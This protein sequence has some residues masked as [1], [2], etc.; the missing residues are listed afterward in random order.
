MT[1]NSLVASQGSPIVLNSE[2][3]AISS[4]PTN[5]G[6][7]EIT[8]R[9]QNVTNLESGESF[10]FYY[11]IAPINALGGIVGEL[12]GEAQ[13]IAPGKDVKVTV[14]GDGAVYYYLVK[15]RLSAMPVD[16]TLKADL[17][18]AES[19]LKQAQ[20]T[21]DT[22]SLKIQQLS[23]EIKSYAGMSTALAAERV[24]DTLV[25]LKMAQDKLARDNDEIEPRTTARDI[26]K[27]A[28]EKATKAAA[29]QVVL[30][31]GILPI[32]K[33]PTLKDYHRKPVYYRF[34]QSDNLETPFRLERMG[35]FPVFTVQDDL[36]LIIVNH[37]QDQK[38]SDF[39]LSYGTTKGSVIDV[40]PVRPTFEPQSISKSLLESDKPDFSHA[41]TDHLLTFA[42]KLPGETVLTVSVSSYA[43]VV[44]TNKDDGKTTTLI[45]ETKTVKLL[46]SELWPQI[47]S[48][49][50]FNL[51]TGV[52]ATW[53]RDPAY[54]RVLTD[55]AIPAKTNPASDQVPAKYR[56][57][58][59]PG[60][61]RAMPILAF[62]GYIIPRDIQVPWRWV[63]LMP[64]PTVGFSLKSPVD[65]FFFGASSE[66]RRNVQLVYGYHFGRIT[67][68]GPSG[69]DDPTSTTAPPTIQRFKGNLFLGLTFNLNFIKGLYK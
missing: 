25:V 24:R 40:A 26:T 69:I 55:A 62:S 57:A 9:I 45:K 20:K 23:E 52:V 8:F 34:M 2:G 5:V 44:T 22:D 13:T 53:L 61:A 7:N 21:A 3:M 48:L 47:H 39:V 35:E 38:P 49:F 32:T 67:R 12:P 14:K 19:A 51:S 37:R 64:A 11:T 68:L 28:L 6:N 60:S 33:G 29:K 30:R 56:S 63:D 43:N 15:K 31:A 50:H 18:K 54:S 17:E 58:T 59:D 66:L 65:D 42:N 36:Y 16:P 27:D 1:S 4:I 10:S 41:Y 46:D